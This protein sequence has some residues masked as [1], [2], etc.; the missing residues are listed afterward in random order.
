MQTGPS[1][2][3]FEN[4][5]RE[6][7]VIWLAAD[8]MT[9]KT[10][11]Q[12]LGISTDTVSTY[13]KRIM[14]KYESSSR[15]EVVA[16]VLKE[17]YGNQVE[18]LEKEKQTLRVNLKAT[19]DAEQ[20]QQIATAHLNSL[21][22]LLDVGV[23]FTSNGLKVTYVNEQLC[24][25]AGCTL[26]PK[27]LIGKSI[28]TFLRDSKNRSMPHIEDSVSRIQT[29]VAAG[30]DRMVDQ[31]VMTDGKI[32]ERTFCTLNVR[33][34]IV[35]H[36]IVYKDVTNFVK[37]HV[38]LRLRNKLSEILTVRA[39]AHLSSP[40]DMQVGEII[41]TL[42]AIAT[43]LGADRSMI[44]EIDLQKGT[45]NIDFAWKKNRTEILA[46]EYQPIPLS[47]FPW[48]RKQIGEREFWIMDTMNEFP[49]IA[50]MEKA[51]YEEDGVRSTIGIS[52]TSTDPNKAYFVD[53][54]YGKEHKLNR[55]VVESLLPIRTILGTVFQNLV[56][57]DKKTAEPSG[58]AD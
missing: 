32:L 15:T 29:L 58:S 5:S 24:Q 40:P 39:M 53:F 50:S 28:E 54:S 35:G 26:A 22:N 52:F 16:N 47:V 46:G 27:E 17:R 37:D 8:G 55:K 12:L 11:A 49:A 42:E 36:L 3:E 21:M 45:F 2:I 18:K 30:T 1:E 13:W 56:R 7:Q 4:M 14:Q 31:L 48:L 57:S 19:K 43:F 9:D 6:Q 20:Q 41:N 44:G 33:G 34:S 51:V 10:I 38:E 25:M 23:L